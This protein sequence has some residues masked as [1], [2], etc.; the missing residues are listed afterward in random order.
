[1]PL[2][3]F[4][5]S[6]LPWGMTCTTSLAVESC[7][8]KSKVYEQFFRILFFPHKCIIMY[9]FVKQ[10]KIKNTFVWFSF[11]VNGIIMYNSIV[12]QHKTKYL[13]PTTAP[14]N[15]KVHLHDNDTKC[16]KY[17][18]IY[19]TKQGGVI[20]LLLGWSNWNKNSWKKYRVTFINK[21]STLQQLL[22][23]LLPFLKKLQLICLKEWLP[24]NL[25]YPRLYSD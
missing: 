25:H 17:Q 11:N 7:F 21:T 5:L 15:S 4:L 9:D 6:V 14:N 10:H 19:R 22:V 2:N 12:K 18:P 23:L 8:P 3:H 16:C 24:F 13:A 1:M 20:A